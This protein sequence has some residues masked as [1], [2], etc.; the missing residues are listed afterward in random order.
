MYQYLTGDVSS[1][2]I[3]QG[4]QDRLEVMLDS[5]DPD[6]WFDLRYHNSGPPER[7]EEFW[8]AMDGIINKNALK[9]VDSRRHGTVCHMAIALFVK[10]LRDKVLAKYPTLAAPCKY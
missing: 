6:V 4:V 1:T 9:A 3:S 2:S 10:N 8:K 5:Q 7:Y